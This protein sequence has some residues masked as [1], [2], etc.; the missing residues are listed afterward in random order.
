MPT[1]DLSCS[2]IISF[3][4]LAHLPNFY[5]I[6]FFS[7][8]DGP[9]FCVCSVPGIDLRTSLVSTLIFSKPFELGTLIIF[10]VQI[11]KLSYRLVI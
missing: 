2:R 10:I 3:K 6:V 9:P 5:C 11:R 8:I 7:N 4:L 1:S